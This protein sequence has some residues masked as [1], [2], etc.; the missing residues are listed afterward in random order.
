[1][2]DLADTVIVVAVLQG[3]VLA[4]VL[5]RRRTNELAN[6]ILAAHVTGVALMLLLGF[7]ERHLGWRGY[8]H[9]LGLAAPVPFLFGPL[10]FLYVTA[11]TRPLAKVDARWAVHALPFVADIVYMTLVFYAKSGDEKLALAE[12]HMAGRGARSIQVVLGLEAVQATSY[13]F[14]SFVE[15]RRYCA[16]CAGISATCRGSISCGSGRRCW[17][18]RRFGAWSS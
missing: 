9:L 13:L 17:P 6:R 11:L 15:L 2:P 16:R 10:L 12:A 1:M 4:V 18:T 3:A 14:A 5:A 7:L 8:P